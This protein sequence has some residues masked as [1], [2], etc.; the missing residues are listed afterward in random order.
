MI[1]GRR[2]TGI[3][4]P[5]F[6]K[7]TPQKTWKKSYRQCIPGWTG[8]GNHF[9]HLKTPFG[10]GKTHTL[11]YLYHKFLKWY[12]KKPI[13]LDCTEMDPNTQTLWGEI[14]RQ[15]TGKVEKLSGNVSRGAAAIRDM[16]GSHQPTLIL[17][18]ELLHYVSKAD[19]V[20][21]EKT[22]LAD[23]TI[24]FVQELSEAAKGLEN[25]CVVVTLLSSTN[26]QL[27]TERAAEMYEKLQKF[28]GRVEDT[29]SPVDDHDIPNI[30]RA[31]LFKN[32]SGQIEDRAEPVIS[33]FVDYCE[34][35]EILPEGMEKSEY[36]RLFE[37]SY[38]F[39]PQVIDVLYKRWGTLQKF[40]RTRGVLRLLSIVVHVLL[41]TDKPFISLGDFDLS[42]EQLAHEL[43]RHL[44]DQFY[45]VIASDIGDGSGA[46]KVNKMLPQ[47]LWAKELGTRAARA[48]FM[49]SHS[50]AENT[51]GA[52]D[53]EV[54]RATLS[55]GIESA[56]IDT[57]LKE[58]QNQ[59]FYLNTKDG[60]YIFT[61]EAN[62]LKMK[63]DKMENIDPRELEEA[64][65]R[66]IQDNTSSDK[67]KVVVWPKN[68]KD[69][70]NSPSMKLVILKKND[71]KLMEE[72]L[73]NVGEQPRLYKN[74]I[75]I[76][77]PSEEKKGMF[78]N[79]LKSRI[80][81][82]QIKDGSFTL[83]AEQRKT[84]AKELAREN[85]NLKYSVKE[86]YSTLYVPKKDGPSGARITVPPPSSLT[87][88]Q[89]VYEYL[90]D[91]HLINE[92]IG[93]IRIKTDYLTGN[94]HVDTSQLYETMLRAP[95]EKRPVSRDVLVNAINRGV[96]EGRFGLGDIEDGAP[97]C[98]HFKTACAASLDP[99]E[100]IIRAELC[101]PRD[102][103]KDRKPK[104]PPTP[105]GTGG[106]QGGDKPPVEPD[107]P[108][109]DIPS[110]HYSFTI[111]EGTV[112]STF[113]MFLNISNKFRRFR[114][115]VDADDGG[116][117]NQD[118]ENIKETLKQMESE[119]DLLDQ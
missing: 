19:G 38:P 79:S 98:R 39:L 8:G 43:V 83:K 5:S 54:M 109:R 78:L 84:L 16:L 73:D 28:S 62:I 94:D 61:K 57:V 11:I 47:N 108:Q 46:S 81:W 53:K 72:I 75:F 114:L 26:E 14:E 96:L 90:K 67:F 80:A 7:H 20:R 76:L 65:R 87:I 10:G 37:K 118:V 111:P 71:G 36:R 44:D 93:P 99:G 77:A 2:S 18:D 110:L 60:K 12:D 95:G 101:A 70:E 91:T 23:Q 88:N 9:R 112:N 92:E 74:N 40:Q 58:F 115:T 113:N 68:S 29:I 117:T 6:R 64:E 105:S 59:L 42:N 17:I 69:I 30:I 100:V 85:D 107:P 97:V 4:R 45:G 31:R 3:R 66:L 104:D 55:R 33:E 89:V 82:E 25:T 52:T 86:Y 48:I 15:L 41:K 49:Y 24:A 119:S 34:E 106:V 102:S 35:Q 27:N 32:P 116:M 22:T 51:R 103:E 50:G 56:N 1:R 63:L 21:V 13:V